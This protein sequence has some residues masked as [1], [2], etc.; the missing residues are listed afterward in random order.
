MDRMGLLIHKLNR[1]CF[2]K[3][4][5]GFSIKETT[6]S[7]RK[8]YS[9]Q[10]KFFKTQWVYSKSETA[11]E[12]Y[13]EA[14]VF[15]SKLP[16]GITYTTE[17]RKLKSLPTF[18]DTRYFEHENYETDFFVH[19]SD[20]YAMSLVKRKGGGRIIILPDIPTQTMN[21]AIK[22]KDNIEAKYSE[23]IEP[24]FDT[25]SGSTALLEYDGFYD[26]VGFSYI[27]MKPLEY[28]YQLWG[29][30]MAYAQYKLKLLKDNEFYIIDT[31]GND[32]ITYVSISK[33]EIEKVS[34]NNWE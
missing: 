9:G 30:A 8:R 7:W 5:K 13:S 22:F 33:Y 34:L 16:W 3:N 15:F 17:T 1:L 28:D 20:E 6:V 25:N 10:S 29:M 12:R 26:G 4:G 27:K 24:F 23:I 32:K 21:E 14:I 11:E 18:V 19:V 2:L 31:D